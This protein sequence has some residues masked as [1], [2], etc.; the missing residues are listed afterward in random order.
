MYQETTA[1][2]TPSDGSW[3]LHD[4]HRPEKK[5][6]PALLTAQKETKEKKNKP[7]PKSSW[8]AGD[9]ILELPPGHWWEFPWRKYSW[10][11]RV[12][13]GYTLRAGMLW[14]LAL[15][16]CFI[17][18]SWHFSVAVT[19]GTRCGD[20]YNI[21]SRKRT[22]QSQFQWAWVWKSDW[23]LLQNKSK[24]LGKWINKQ[25]K[26]AAIPFLKARHWFFNACGWCHFWRLPRDSAL[27]KC[28]G[29]AVSLLWQVFTSQHC[30][31][32]VPTEHTAGAGEEKCKIM[33]YHSSPTAQRSAQ[34]C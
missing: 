29:R 8:R 10:D 1:L 6:L 5:K 9:N 7:A 13:L 34:F 18:Y 20:N 28:V 15:E 23:S 11:F 17:L 25:K 22:C 16:L 32:K 2:P 24:Q 27:R 12:T 3:T 14:K 26:I 33:C 31:P 21:Y 30:P 4:W 19:P